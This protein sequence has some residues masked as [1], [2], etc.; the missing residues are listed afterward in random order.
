VLREAG[1]S[2]FSWFVEKKGRKQTIMPVYEMAEMAHPVYGE[3][4]SERRE[5]KQNKSRV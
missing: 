4:V 1:F 5:N 2:T 3:I